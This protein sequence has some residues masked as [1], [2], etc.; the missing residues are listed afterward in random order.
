MPPIRLPSLAVLFLFAVPATAQFVN[1]AVWLGFEEE[2][3][4]RHFAQGT[5][6][7]LDRFSYVVVAP[8]WERGLPNFGNRVGYRLGSTSGSHFAVEGAIDH[9]VP[10]G[11]GLLFRYHARQG[12]NRDTRFVRN[13]VVRGAASGSA[14]CGRSGASAN[15]PRSSHSSTRGSS[16]TSSAMEARPATNG[17]SKAS[18]PGTPVGTSRMPCRWR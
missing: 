10:L 2:G 6:Y 5:E 18:W 14:S 16:T 11:D 1:R 12:E 15:S 17:D 7:F 3:M 13:S 9:V 8:W 4:R